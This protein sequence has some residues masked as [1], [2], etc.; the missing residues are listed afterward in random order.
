MSA[1]AVETVSLETSALG[2]THNKIVQKFGNVK[3]ISST[4]LIAMPSDQYVIFDVREVEEF[5]ISHLQDAI[6]LDPDM[7]GEAFLKAYSHRLEN[8]TAVFYCSVGM[9]SSMMVDRVQRALPEQH[10]GSILNL[11]GGI[12]AWHN[13]SYPLQ[14]SRG[15]TDAIH[16]YNAFW[17]RMLK[18]REKTSYGT[19]ED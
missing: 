6:R 5:E 3:H 15:D 1:C 4:D 19:I 18:R 13:Q 7:N 8:K 2:E 14:N 9:R 17:G 16:P 12:F 10:S 11:Q